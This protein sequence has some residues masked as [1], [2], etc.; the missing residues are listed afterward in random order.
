VSIRGVTEANVEEG[1]VEVE[2]NLV[3]TIAKAHDT[4]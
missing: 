4:T 1:L 2:G 3:V